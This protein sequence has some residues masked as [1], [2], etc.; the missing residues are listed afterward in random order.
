MFFEILR[1]ELR[2]Q[3]KAPLFWII[4]AAYAAIAFVLGSTDAVV[5]GGASGNVLRNAPL[6]TVRLLSGLT[7][8]CLLLA[9]AFVAGAALRDF[10]LGTSELVFSTPLRK[11][12]YL[13]GRF[14]AGVLVMVAIM[15]LC[16]LGLAV[17]G[18]MPWIDATRL[19]PPSWHGYAWAFGVMVLPNLLF[20][21][22]VLFLLA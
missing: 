17:G 19:G 12:D 10:D 1:F 2:Q 18:S 13:G 22:S 20:I 16:A 11:R 7:P 21:A 9:A 6:V 5:A 14:T 8:L 4:A 15:L 3:L